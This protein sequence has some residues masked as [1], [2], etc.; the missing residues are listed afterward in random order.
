MIEE[1]VENCDTY[2]LCFE[3]SKSYEKNT[4]VNCLNICQVFPIDYVTRSCLYGGQ[5]PEGLMVV[6]KQLQCML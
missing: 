2:E 4:K 3:A 6:R 5:I 1:M